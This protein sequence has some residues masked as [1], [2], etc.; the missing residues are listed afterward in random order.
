M[1]PRT[2]LRFSC[3]DLK[4]E[5][6]NIGIELMVTVILVGVISEQ[7]TTNK[8]TKQAHISLKTKINSNKGKSHLKIPSTPLI[9]L[10]LDEILT[11]K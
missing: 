9:I 11:Y 1:T 2:I 4:L 7:R 10:S 6:F 8:Q 5:P 3:H